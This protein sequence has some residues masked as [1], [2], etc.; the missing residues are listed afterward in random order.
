M[1]DHDRALAAGMPLSIG[2]V[3]SDFYA[4]WQANQVDRLHGMIAQNCALAA[5]HDAYDK[6]VRTAP[7]RFPAGNDLQMQLD[8]AFDK[9]REYGISL[10]ASPAGNDPSVEAYKLFRKER[11]AKEE[12]QAEAERLRTFVRQVAN[13]EFSDAG[14]AKRARELMAGLAVPA[15]NS[16]HIAW[17]AFAR[18]SEIMTRDEALELVLDFADAVR[19]SDRAETGHR[20]RAFTEYVDMREKLVDTLCNCAAVPPQE[21]GRT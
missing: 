19:Q 15:E 7:N 12:A 18:R 3:Q 11:R 2:D 6:Y 5:W 17:V 8:A 10:M 21:G 9:G 13:H 1:T 16:G 20:N 14:N 4:W